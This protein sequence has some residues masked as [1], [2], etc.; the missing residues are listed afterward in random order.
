MRYLLPAYGSFDTYRTSAGRRVE[1]DPHQIGCLTTPSVRRIPQC[2]REGWAFGIDNEAFTGKY[3]FQ[4]FFSYLERFTPYAANCLFAVVPDVVGN[5]RD[6]ILQYEMLWYGA[7]TC[8]LPPA[9]VAQDGQED[10]DFP[11]DE[12]LI[13]T[14]FIGGSTEWK[15]SN[16]ALSVIERAQA[17]GYKVHAGRVNSRQRYDHF[18]QAGVDSADGT[19]LVYAKD[20]HIHTI[21][22]WG[23][24]A[25][26]ALCA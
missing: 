14:V 20:K 19:Y 13:D 26:L 21:R 18:H 6:T 12:C 16:A 24:Q 10:L 17:A 3:T 25:Q 7:V 2:V 5:A 15:L 4:R 22:A 9:F 8:D 1:L 11:D 23:Y